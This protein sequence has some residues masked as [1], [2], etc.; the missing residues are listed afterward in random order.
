[1]TDY[2]ED[3]PLL[4][5]YYGFEPS[6]Y[7]LRFKSRGD[8]V[9]SERVVQLYKEVEPV[10]YLWN[11]LT[12]R[13]NYQAGLAARLTPRSEPRGRD[14]R[15]FNGPGLDHGVFVPFRLMF[16]EEFIDVPIV[17][18]SID[19]SLSPEKNWTVGE[20]L[21]PLRSGILRRTTIYPIRT[22]DIIHA[23]KKGF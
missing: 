13:R 19:A 8:H 3:N 21:A 20:V 2:G 5:D 22:A 14:G 4:M 1:V 23:G 18:V 11:E 17:Q 10:L 12:Y 7:E 16:G 6:L 15:G 9:L